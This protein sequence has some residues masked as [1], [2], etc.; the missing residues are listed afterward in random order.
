MNTTVDFLNVVKCITFVSRFSGRSHFSN[1]PEMYY[2]Y[3]GFQEK[4][5]EISELDITG[6][7]NFSLITG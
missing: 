3:M 7:M 4:R 5:D 1:H 2:K 6:M